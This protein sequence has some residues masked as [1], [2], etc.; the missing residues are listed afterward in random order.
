MKKYFLGILTLTS[1]TFQAQMNLTFKV[2]NSPTD[3][4]LVINHDFSKW[5]IADK[6][7]DFKS[8]L[9][10]K[11]GFY[12]LKLADK[13]TE[14]YL[15]KDH[16]LTGISDYNNFKKSLVYTGTNA[17]ENNFL[18]KKLAA[19]DDNY[20]EDLTNSSNENELLAKMNKIKETAFSLIT[21][22]LPKPFIIS[23][24][25]HTESELKEMLEYIK[26]SLKLKKL[27]GTISPTFNY[28]NHKGGTTKLENF[29][30]KYVYIDIW[31]TW[32]GPCRAEIPYLKKLEK[33]F[34][35]KNIEF[36]SISID[37]Q[38]DHDKWKKFVTEKQLGGT[39][40]IADQDWNSDFIKAYIV[41]GIP[42]FILIDPDGKIINIDA[43]RP[44]SEEIKNI[45][46]NLIK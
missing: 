14:V 20:Y 29:R 31:A 36:I 46:N 12:I 6:N 18:A 40:L 22:D 37:S 38:K 8:K 26:E 3:S 42:R 9:A 11:E 45:F 17:K 28:E 19:Q 5:I 13:H 44:S 7:G 32:C 10:A 27:N 35:G 34:H 4:L 16:H 1:I 39:Q 43:P 25:K 23:F 15:K 21:N 2:K 30:G 41:N 24:K 33:H